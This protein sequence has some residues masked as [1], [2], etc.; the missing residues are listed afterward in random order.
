MFAK[1]D[2]KTQWEQTLLELKQKIAASLECPPAPEFLTSIPIRKTRAGLQFTCAAPTLAGN[3][4]GTGS[5]TASDVWVCNSDG[6][7]GQ[8]CVLS[9]APEPSVIS[10]NSVCNARILCVESV[11]HSVQ[12]RY[13]PSD[14]ASAGAGSSSAEPSSK[15][16]PDLSSSGDEAAVASAAAAAVA[17]SS[18]SVAHVAD[19]QQSTMWLGMEDGYVHVYNCSDN[20]RIK[21]TKI[22]MQHGSAVTDIL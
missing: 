22:K 19:G 20:I 2:K 7:V 3:G 11:P 13:Q 17:S 14:G 15:S 5:G 9:L 16:L 8:V 1:A 6:Y 18:T 4:T 21:N 12:S 10:C